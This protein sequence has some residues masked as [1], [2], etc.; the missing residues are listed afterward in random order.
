MTPQAGLHTLNVADALDVEREYL[1]FV[2]EGAVRALVVVFHPFGSRPELVLDGGTDGDYLQR[3]L[4][5]AVSS[6]EQLGLALLAPRSRGRALDGVSLAWMGH[7]DAVWSVAD[8]LRE[9]FGLSST[10]AGGLSMGGLEALVFAGQ[11]PES[12][13]AAW[14]AN[15]IVDLAHWRRDLAAPGGLEGGAG[16][17]ELIGTE[18]GGT[19]EELP[20]EYAARSPFDY[21]DALAGVR[22]RIA[23]SPV[24]AVIPNQATAHSH[25]LASRL[26]ERGGV[27][28]EDVVT[29]APTD[30]KTDPGRFAHEACDTREAMGWIAEQLTNTNHSHTGGIA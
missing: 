1:L 3:P 15:P 18:V 23:W 7:L 6:A 28:V 9:E 11:H 8:G 27:V 22:V 21:L 26:R 13:V 20:D 17:A 2:P 25:P 29:H 14:A 24:D 12:V 19:P 10:G 5:G 4:T 16:L 30:E